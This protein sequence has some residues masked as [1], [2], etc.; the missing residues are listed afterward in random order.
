MI[1][2]RESDMVAVL[3]HSRIPDF[4]EEKLVKGDYAGHA[5]HVKAEILLLTLPCKR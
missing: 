3:E 5:K 4:S 2:F 1:M